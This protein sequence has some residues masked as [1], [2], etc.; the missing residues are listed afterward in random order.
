MSARTLRKLRD[1]SWV[2]RGLLLE[3]LLWLELTRWAL[4][5]VPFKYIAHHLGRHMTESDSEVDSTTAA[6]A[7]RI[8]W[9]VRAVACRTLWKSTCLTQAIAAKRMLRRRGIFSTLYLGLTKDD[10]RELQAHAW[11]RCGSH[12]LTGEPSHQ[13]FAVVS[14]FAESDA[15]DQ[16]TI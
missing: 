6:Q 10:D 7:Q 13:R 8:G 5:T 12:I 4:L 2:D 3:A 1:L 16:E 9:A 14:T 11:L 15:K